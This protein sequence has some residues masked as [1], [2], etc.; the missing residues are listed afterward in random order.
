MSDEEK[1]D[2]LS[3]DQRPLLPAVALLQKM[4]RRYFDAM[5]ATRSVA[6]GRHLRLKGAARTRTVAARR[7]ELHAAEDALRKIVGMHQRLLFIEFHPKREGQMAAM[8]IPQQVDFYVHQ[9][10]RVWTLFRCTVKTPPP[11]L[12]FMPVHRANAFLED[13]VHDWNLDHNRK[14]RY[15]SRVTDAPVWVLVELKQ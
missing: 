9:V 8:A 14:F 4:I 3:F 6:P 11:P 12:P 5:D 13:P 7:R 1:K 15:A 10:E 2:E